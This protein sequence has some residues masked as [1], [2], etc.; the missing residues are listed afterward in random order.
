MATPKARPSDLKRVGYQPPESYRLDL[1]VLSMSELRRRVVEDEA[2]LAHRIDFHILIHVTRGNCTHT[3]DFTPI[4]CGAGSMLAL[5]P[6]QAQRFD[7][8]SQWEGWIAIFRSEFLLPLQSTA[9][10]PELHM[11]SDLEALPEHL[12]LAGTDRDAVGRAFAQMHEDTQLSG[13]AT[14]LNMLLRHQ[15]SALLT[16]LHLIDVRQAPRDSAASPNLQRFNRFKQRLEKAFARQHQVAG[17]AKQLGCSE[18]SLNRAT[19]DVAGLTAKAYIAARINL[20]AKRLLAHTALPIGQIADRLGF[21]EPTNFVKFFK[22]EV[23]CSPSEFR[24]RHG[25]ASV[26]SPAP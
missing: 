3:V 19:L 2:R 1:E 13:P 17:Y 6:A 10:S 9:S 7:F 11:V 23:G 15:L 18:K 26:Q 24:R 5:R 12:A 22:R 20:E 21:D 8:S 4:A 16:R 14:E 25:D